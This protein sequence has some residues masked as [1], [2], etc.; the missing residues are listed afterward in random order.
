VLGAQVVGAGASEL[1]AE[2]TLGRGLETTPLE[3]GATVHAHPTFA[4]AVREA[5]L[6]LDGGAIHFFA[7][8]VG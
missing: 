2:V 4:E 7:K 3:I 5:A 6:M 8:R 1:I